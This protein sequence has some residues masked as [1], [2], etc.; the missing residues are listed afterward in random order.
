MFRELLRTNFCEENLSFW[1]EL[2][3]LK[4][5]FCITSST[6]A[7]SQNLLIPGKDTPGRA[8]MERHHDSLT[9]M[10]FTIYNMHLVPSSQYKLNIDHGHRGELM[11]Y[12]SKAITDITGQVFQYVGI[13]YMV[14]LRVCKP[15]PQ[16]VR[17]FFVI[18]THS[19]LTTHHSPIATVT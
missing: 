14:C 16:W 1:L 10:A 5:K 9:Q 3:G 8:A 18:T 13:W 19:P 17:E 4:N 6:T 7:G 12:F 2:E 15:A 11:T